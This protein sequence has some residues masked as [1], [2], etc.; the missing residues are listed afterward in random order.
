MTFV[1]TEPSTS[2]PTVPSERAPITISS[3]SNR[4]AASRISSAG[5]STGA[6][7]VAATPARSS[8]FRPVE[9]RLALAGLQQGR[10]FCAAFYAREPTWSLVD[11]QF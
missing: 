5:W 2:R 1:L 9:D 6:S 4:F 7:T 11:P 8:P 3:A 10:R